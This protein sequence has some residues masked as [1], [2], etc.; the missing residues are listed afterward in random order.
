MQVS[1]PPGSAAASLSIRAGSFNLNVLKLHPTAPGTT[2]SSV[3][4][5]LI[6]QHP[7]PMA[8]VSGAL[9]DSQL[10]VSL[11]VRNTFLQVTA[12]LVLLICGTLVPKT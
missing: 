9:S 8:S 6:G 3:P 10:S 7:T 5:A 2:T 11:R 1:S 12:D 4:C